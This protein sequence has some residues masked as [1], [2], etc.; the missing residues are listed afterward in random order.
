MS[1]NVK[2]VLFG[3]GPSD[4]PAVLSNGGENGC[5]WIRLFTEQ[6]YAFCCKNGFRATSN[7]H[8]V[9][10][11]VVLLP[12]GDRVGNTLMDSLGLTLWI[13]VHKDMPAAFICRYVQTLIWDF[14]FT[15]YMN[16]VLH[17]PL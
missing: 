11:G 8:E 1:A 4:I 14:P 6:D 13:V 9:P 3:A 5:L 2:P 10:V 7:E 12:C 16:G 15:I 17:D